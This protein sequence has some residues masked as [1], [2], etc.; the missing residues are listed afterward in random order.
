MSIILTVSRVPGLEFTRALGHAR[1]LAHALD[2]FSAV[3]R[4]KA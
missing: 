2:P 4:G 3:S 1:D